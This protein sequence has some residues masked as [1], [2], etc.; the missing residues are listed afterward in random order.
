MEQHKCQEFTN[1]IGDCLQDDTLDEIRASRFVTVSLD[2]STDSSV[3]ESLYPYESTCEPAGR[4]RVAEDLNAS[5]LTEERDRRLLRRSHKDARREN[6]RSVVVP[7]IGATSSYVP[8]QFNAVLFDI[9]F[10][11]S[12]HVP[13]LQPARSTSL[14]AP[15]VSISST[16]SNTSIHAYV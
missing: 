14:Y 16:A 7:A 2:G 1:I 15:H 5:P 12:K 13:S 6:L 9:S 8:R 4:V 10:L 11:Q 3:R